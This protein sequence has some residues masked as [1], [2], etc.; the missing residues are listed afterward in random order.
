MNQ[1]FSARALYSYSGPKTASPTNFPLRE[2]KFTSVN[3]NPKAKID[4]TELLVGEK[5]TKV[6]TTGAIRTQ[7]TTGTIEH[8]VQ[9]GKIELKSGANTSTTLS[10]TALIAKST[11]VS[12][13]ATGSLA[14]SGST[15]VSIRSNSLTTIHGSVVTISTTTTTFAGGI[16]TSG[17]INPMTGAPFYVSLC[18]GNPSTQIV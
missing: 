4:V 1:S 9:A 2:T 12:V 6:K 8:K 16:L 18:F 3:P 5:I 10:A 7:V 13:Q 11:F 15:S 17:T 14:L